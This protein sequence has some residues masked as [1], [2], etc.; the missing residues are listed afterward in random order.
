MK[1]EKPINTCSENDD[2]FARTNDKQGYMQCQVHLRDSDKCERKNMSNIQ[3]KIIKSYNEK[4]PT[5][6]MNED[7]P[8]YVLGWN[9]CK[10]LSEV[11]LKSACKQV[12]EDM[13][14]EIMVGKYNHEKR[15]INKN[16]SKDEIYCCCDCY[17]DGQKDK[18]IDEIQQK[19]IDYIKNNFT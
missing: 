5:R 17:D 3:S 19:G 4:I 18:A 12:A 16:H 7:N 2:L 15:G 14:K 8:Q 9:A 13:L 11:E 1:K 10:Y 6:I